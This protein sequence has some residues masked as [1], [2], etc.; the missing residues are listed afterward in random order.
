MKNPRSKSITKIMI[1][2]PVGER[3]HGKFL[4]RIVPWFSWEGVDCMVSLNGWVGMVAEIWR[5]CGDEKRG[6]G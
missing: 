4:G 6:K 5:W 2:I 3:C 1:I